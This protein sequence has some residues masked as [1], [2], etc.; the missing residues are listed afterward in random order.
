[1]SSPREEYDPV[2]AEHARSDVRCFGGVPWAVWVFR[3]QSVDQDRPAILEK[4]RSL[5]GHPA[6]PNG[7]VIKD[8]ERRK[9]DFGEMPDALARYRETTEAR[10][11]SIEWVRCIR[12]GHS[13]SSFSS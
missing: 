1:M 3:L 2:C 7:E 13:M 9:G 6:K 10:N 8:A 5:L 12:N 11:A 4:I